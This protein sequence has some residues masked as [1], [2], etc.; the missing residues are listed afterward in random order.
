MVSGWRE[1]DEYGEPLEGGT[2]DVDWT[3]V[4][5]TGSV[6]CSCGWEGRGA[7]LLRLGNDG[8]PLPFIHPGQQ[9]IQ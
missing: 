9:E 3:E 8:Q 2:R 6:G 5:D 4:E 1:L 7:A